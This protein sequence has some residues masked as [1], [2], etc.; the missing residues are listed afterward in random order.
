MKQGYLSHSVGLWGSVLSPCRHG[1]GNSKPLAVNFPLA[2]GSDLILV[3][4]S[5]IIFL[6]YPLVQEEKSYIV[7]S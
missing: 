6:C 2:F 5:L 3:F 7:L 4:L 1:R